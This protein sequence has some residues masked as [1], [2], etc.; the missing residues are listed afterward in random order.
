MFIVV[1]YI[2]ILCVTFLISCVRFLVISC[3]KIEVLTWYIILYS[4]FI[5]KANKK[6]NKH[7]IDY[8]PIRNCSGGL[9]TGGRGGGPFWCLQ[10]QLLFVDA[11]H[12]VT[13]TY[14][15]YENIL[16]VNRYPQNN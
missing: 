4:C 13:F 10:M 8:S 6:V 3:A 2:L 14:K 16:I 5:N 12:F 7:C 11:C 15:L 9:L 1:N